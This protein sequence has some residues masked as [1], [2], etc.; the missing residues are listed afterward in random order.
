[1]LGDSDPEGDTFTAVLLA[2]PTNGTLTL[3]ADGSFTYT[4]VAG[5]TGTDSFTYE[6]WDGSASSLS[7]QVTISVL[8]VFV[9]PPTPDPEPEPEPEPDPEPD[10]D[11]EPEPDDPEEPEVEGE[12]TPTTIVPTAPDTTVTP[13][14]EPT[15]SPEVD[16]TVEEPESLNQSLDSQ[17][18]ATFDGTAN[19]EIRRSG[20]G[21]GT[22]VRRASLG[23]GAGQVAINLD[24]ALMASP[25]LMWS[26]LDQQMDSVES[27]IH[28]DLIL[29]GAAG[30]AASSFTVGL[31]AWTLRTGFLAS[32]LLAQMPA[33][34]ALDPLLI[35]Q[36]LS[37]SGD[38]ESLQELMNRRIESLDDGEQ[39]ITPVR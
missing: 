8:P 39:T 16:E 21:S 35:M 15:T 10:K 19:D 7:A 4:P 13:P 28:G 30:A 37:E 11:P 26:E 17:T 18:Q 14:A 9:P 38:E 25:G 36:G 20:G 29:V 27:H 12:T 6:A 3:N 31:V 23:Q 24:H 5:F 22:A 32:G 2:G 1:L 34:R 33:W